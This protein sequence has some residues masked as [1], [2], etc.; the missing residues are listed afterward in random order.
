MFIAALS[1][2]AKKWKQPKCPLTDEWI[3]KMWCIYI[4]MCVYIYI[5]THT[6]THTHTIYKT[7]I[8]HRLRKQTYGYQRGK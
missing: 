6:H 4:C 1:T 5:Y 8:D 2:I 7:E 3:K